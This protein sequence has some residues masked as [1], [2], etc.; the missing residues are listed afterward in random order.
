[1]RFFDPRQED[2]PVR[3]FLARSF[4]AAILVVATLVAA[5][6]ASGLSA[7]CTAKVY[8]SSWLGL[9]TQG[10]KAYC[11]SIGADTKVRAHHHNWGRDAYSEYFTDL[12]R[13][14]YSGHS[15]RSGWASADMAPR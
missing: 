11:S 8:Y 9:T 10:A 3:S 2:V 14:H 1:M 15:W 7:S 13:W 4:L 6:P 12:Y 5:V